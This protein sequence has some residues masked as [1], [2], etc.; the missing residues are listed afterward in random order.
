MRTEGPGEAVLSRH[1]RQG[2]ALRP[3]GHTL[4]RQAAFSSPFGEAPKTASAPRLCWR[5][6]EKARMN[7]NNN[8]II[9]FRVARLKLLPLYVATAYTADPNERTPPP[10]TSKVA[11]SE[12]RFLIF[13]KLISGGLFWERG[14]CARYKR[15]FAPALKSV[16]GATLLHIFR[17]VKIY[18][19]SLYFHFCGGRAP[20]HPIVA[21]I[22]YLRGQRGR[23]GAQGNQ[24]GSPDP[25]R[26]PPF[27]VIRSRGSLNIHSHFT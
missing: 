15:E 25:M 5:Q 2:T 27:V 10:R 11:L 19:F 20:P 8:N 14:G 7:I 1:T 16:N 23:R 18:N 13:R 22:K 21:H 26:P 9:P 4:G 12:V 17:K 3:G 24:G 6:K